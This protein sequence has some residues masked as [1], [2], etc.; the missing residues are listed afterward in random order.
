[1]A[2]VL[3]TVALKSIGVGFSFW[4]KWFVKKGIADEIETM[5]RLS[6]TLWLSEFRNKHVEFKNK[7]I[8]KGYGPDGLKEMTTNIYIFDNILNFFLDIDLFVV[9]IF[10]FATQLVRLLFGFLAVIS[11]AYSLRCYEKKCLNGDCFV[12]GEMDCEGEDYNRCGTMTYKYWTNSFTAYLVKNCTRSVMDCNP[13][14]LC[15]RAKRDIMGGVTLSKC[16]VSCCDG[17]MCNGQ[18]EKE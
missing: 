4:D 10:L 7:H 18:G 13:G 9:L 2:G 15:D 14:K 6:F 5:S 17:D 12:N 11:P 3:S 8:G 1:M 16:W